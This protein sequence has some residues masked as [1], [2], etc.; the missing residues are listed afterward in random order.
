[1]TTNVVIYVVMNTTFWHCAINLV[2]D[3]LGIF[4]MHDHKQI[5]KLYKHF[6]VYYNF[7][8][9]HKSTYCMVQTKIIH[10]MVTN[11]KMQITITKALKLLRKTYSPLLSNLI[12]FT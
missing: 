10:N 4:T 9:L 3:L 1:M 7:I 12:E 11:L 6:N 5:L 8:R 2:T